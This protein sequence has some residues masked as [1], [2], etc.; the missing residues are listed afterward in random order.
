MKM[1][2]PV[3]ELSECILCEVCSEACPSV[4]RI[5]DAGYVEVADLTEYPVEEV[6]EAIKHCPSE[7]I[8][9]SEG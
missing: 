7:C 2:I 5:N 9:W 8:S 1:N 4:F 3:I 6:D